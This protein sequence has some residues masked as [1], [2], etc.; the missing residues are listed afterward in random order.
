MINDINEIYGIIG[1]GKYQLYIVIIA[2]VV[3]FPIGVQEFI[4]FFLAFN[5]GWKCRNGSMSCIYNI[6]IL[7]TDT[8]DKQRCNLNTSDWIYAADKK[9][10]IVTEVSISVLRRYVL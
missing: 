7:P 9:F 3:T 1:D 2:C 4:V 8:L 5:P 10:S 6:T